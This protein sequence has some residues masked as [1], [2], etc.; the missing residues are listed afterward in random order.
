MDHLVWPWRQAE[1]VRTQ[2]RNGL[3]ARRLTHT[4][5]PLIGHVVGDRILG[6]VGNNGR[7][8]SLIL[9]VAIPFRSGPF[10]SVP[11][12]SFPIRSCPVQFVPFHSVP[13]RSVH[14]MRA[15]HL[16]NIKQ[17]RQFRSTVTISNEQA[18]KANMECVMF[19]GP[20]REPWYAI[21][22]F[23]LANRWFRLP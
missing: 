16:S 1:L 13:F 23:A 18:S 12:R 11:L 9:L 4:S 8:S 7:V 15:K 14:N 17:R 6:K 2:E 21:P 3:V 22:R 20:L 10:D 5:L 19:R